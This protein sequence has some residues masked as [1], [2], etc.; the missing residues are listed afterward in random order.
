MTSFSLSV[1]VDLLFISGWIGFEIC[2][3]L[4]I[5]GPEFGGTASIGLWVCTV[6]I[7]F[8]AS[9]NPK[10]LISNTDFVS[11]FL[12]AGSATD[13]TKTLSINIEQGMVKKQKDVNGKEV[14]FINP[15]ELLI[16]TDCF[17]PASSYSSNVVAPT[18]G[19]TTTAFTVMPTNESYSGANSTHV[20]TVEKRQINTTTNEVEWVTDTSDFVVTSTSKNAP[21]SMWMKEGD[22]DSSSVSELN[23]GT[24]ITLANPVDPAWTGGVSRK[25]LDSGAVP[26]S[27]E[28]IAAESTLDLSEVPSG[29]SPIS[30]NNVTDLESLFSHLTA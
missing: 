21:K 11:G 10:P 23:F 1:K 17:I 24:E 5:H 15:K 14:Y 7:N 29:T 8:G 26:L 28:I 13:A 2:E 27:E 18:G 6:H 30:S 22:S 19:T 20:V 12:P 9:P 25:N 3:G 16:S 4:A